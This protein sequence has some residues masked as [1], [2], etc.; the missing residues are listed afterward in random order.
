MNVD[1]SYLNVN[2][3]NYTICTCWDIDLAQMRKYLKKHSSSTKS[4]T[5]IKKQFNK[6]ISATGASNGC[7]LCVDALADN[8]ERESNLLQEKKDNNYKLF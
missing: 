1:Q 7:G 2:K 8:Y 5:E 6:F 4:F 3:K